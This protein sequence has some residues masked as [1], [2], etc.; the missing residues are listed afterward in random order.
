MSN[1]ELSEQISSHLQD[2]KLSDSDQRS[3]LGMARTWVDK[4]EP[5]VPTVA[6][7]FH[8]RDELAQGLIDLL[9]EAEPEEAIAALASAREVINAPYKRADFV[10]TAKVKEPKRGRVES[11]NGNPV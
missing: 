2:S 3:A 8:R 1:N 7:E 6:R 9:V 4:R 10:G 5:F 11:S